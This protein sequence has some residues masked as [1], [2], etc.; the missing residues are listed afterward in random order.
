LN[1]PFFIKIDKIF[2]TKKEETI[3]ATKKSIWVLFGVLLISAWVLGSV[4]LVGAE[5]MK[6]R[7]AGTAIKDETIPVADEQ[8]HELGLQLGQGLGFFDNGEIAKMTNYNIY[9]RTGKGS[10][11]IGYTIYTF[12]DGSTII[13]RFQ[14]LVVVDKSGNRSAQVT[15]ELVK[16]TGRYA[17]IKGTVVGT[18]K[19]FQ[20]NKEEPTRYFND[21]TLTY[22]L[23]TK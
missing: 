4:I 18:G 2:K 21:I 5:T 20:G 22:T 6:C 9:D 17:G 3:M 11:V 8:G 12:D 10:Q 15:A 13:T 19:N 16:G 14:R 7:N 1:C 23:P